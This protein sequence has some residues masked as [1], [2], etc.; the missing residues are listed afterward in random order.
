MSNKKKR[1]DRFLKSLREKYRDSNNPLNIY[2]T[3]MADSE[4]IDIMVK[5]FLGEDYYISDPVSPGQANV[6]LAY[7]II[8]RN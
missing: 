5:Y 7:E 1:R 3:N 8:S 6:L 2:P 4:F